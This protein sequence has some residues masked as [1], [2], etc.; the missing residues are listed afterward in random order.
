MFTFVSFPT[1]SSNFQI[2]T[3]GLA[4]NI[5]R[6]HIRQSPDEI[7]AIQVYEDDLLAISKI[8]E[9]GLAPFIGIL[10]A[11]EVN[12]KLFVEVGAICKD[13]NGASVIF[14][15]SNFDGTPN[16]VHVDM[17]EFNEIGPNPFYF[18]RYMTITGNKDAEEDY[19]TAVKL[20]NG[21]TN[22]MT[23]EREI[24]RLIKNWLNVRELHVEIIGPWV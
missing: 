12:G 11:Y 9:M 21:A 20:L 4:V 8:S 6:N 5:L 10:M 15:D 22:R 19:R 18:Q 16:Q 3:K 2:G 23:T 1:S 7:V 14:V 13:K 24:H 17:L